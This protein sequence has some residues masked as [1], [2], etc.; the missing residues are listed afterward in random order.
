MNTLRRY[1]V[2]LCVLA[3]IGVLAAN[4]M[5]QEPAS[6]K[7]RELIAVLTSD[8]PKAE[9]AITCK[10]LAVH[11]S[12]AAVPELAK[13]LPDDEL[14]SWARIALE[15]IPGTEADAALREAS[16]SL[17][18]RLL[19]GVINSIA[20]RRDAAAVELLTKRLEDADALVASSAAA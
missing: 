4:A 20:V 3:A 12:A 15:A 11:G 2:S 7:E 8:A 19:V 9:K 10:F 16:Q 1:V 5:A 18:G 6:D 13:L 14:N 17:E